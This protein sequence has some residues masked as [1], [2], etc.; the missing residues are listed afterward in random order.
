M[1]N[2]VNGVSLQF[3]VKWIVERYSD[4]SI[5]RMKAMEAATR[6]ESKNA[7]KDRRSKE[8]RAASKQRPKYVL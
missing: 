4:T 8:G 7:Q 5:W 2:V 3:S 6:Q 1:V